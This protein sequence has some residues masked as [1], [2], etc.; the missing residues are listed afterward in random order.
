[1]ILKELK[2]TISKLRKEYFDIELSLWFTHDDSRIPR[3]HAFLFATWYF[4]NCCSHGIF[5]YARLLVCMSA[6]SRF[7]PCLC[8]SVCMHSF[9]IVR[10][11]SRLKALQRIVYAISNT[12][13][14]LCNTYWAPLYPNPLR[15]SHVHMH[16]IH[17]RSHAHSIR[18]THTHTHAH[19]HVHTHTVSHTHTRTHTRT[20]THIHTYIYT[21]NMYTYIHHIRTFPST[22]H[23]PQASPSFSTHCRL[24]TAT[25]SPTH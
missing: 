4:K 12:G 13:I 18:H 3:M 11:F 10:V 17:M 19:A 15:P 2:L 14:H 16:R 20:H 8:V 22:L 5:M 21:Y 1:M 7:C 9:K 6:C 24:Q 23:L 25:H